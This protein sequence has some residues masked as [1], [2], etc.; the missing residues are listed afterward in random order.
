MTVRNTAGRNLPRDGIIGLERK[1]FSTLHRRPH[2][3][4]IG[5][6]E[7]RHAIGQCRLADTLRAADQPGMRNAPA[8][9]GVQ[10]RR[11]RL[12]MAEQLGRF[13]GMP[14]RYLR[15]GLA[16]AHAELALVG[17]ANR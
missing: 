11:L 8:A 12:A 9:I 5:E 7:P 13:T 3:I 2:G 4:S 10:Q 17:M 14:D 16:G 15:F 1:R 6:H